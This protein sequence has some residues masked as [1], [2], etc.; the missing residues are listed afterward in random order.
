MKTSKRRWLIAQDYEKSF[1]LKLK[2]KGYDCN[3][4]IDNL[5]YKIK[6]RIKNDIEPYAKLDENSKI[7]QIGGGCKDIIN[8]WDIGK[9]FA[10]DPLID[11]YLKNFKVLKNQVKFSAGI[12]E[13]LPYIS[14]C[15]DVVFLINVLDHTQQPEK[16][17]S[18]IHRTLKKNG[19]LY[20]TVNTFSKPVSVAR[21]FVELFKIDTG[22]PHTFTYNSITNLLKNNFK[23]ALNKAIDRKEVIDGMRGNPSFKLKMLGYLNIAVIPQTFICIKI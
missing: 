9:R 23:I 21:Y 7:L 14:D 10:I 15:F 2:D 17:L 20:L 22:H 13:N 3:Q 4:D 19:I 11:F 12:G 18:E 1:W 5:F 8:F 16:V 6:E